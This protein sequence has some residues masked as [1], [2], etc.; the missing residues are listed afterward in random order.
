MKEP[1]R[2]YLITPPTIELDTFAPMLEAA[3]D[4]GDVACLQLRLKNVDDDTVRRATARLLP[5]CHARDVPL[6]VNDR[7]DL[8]AEMGA[9]GVHVGA[10]DVDYA[11]AR[12]AVGDT[13]TVGVSC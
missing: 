11:E 5:I 2:L 13:A 12:A 4:A 7:A 3:L 6:V 8:A 10:D 9:D 1:C